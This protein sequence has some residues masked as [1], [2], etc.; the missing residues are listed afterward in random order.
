MQELG[1]DLTRHRSRALDDLSLGDFDVVISLSP[2]AA[3][4]FDPPPTGITIE[5]WEVE[6][7]TVAEGNRDARLDAYRRVRLALEQRI[8]ARFSTESG[9]SP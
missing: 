7:P 9:K 8:A 6:D 4:A 3:A 2:E 5:H 1:V